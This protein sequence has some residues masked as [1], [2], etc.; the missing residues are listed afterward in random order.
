[1]TKLRLPLL[2]FPFLRPRPPAR[3][4]PPMARKTKTGTALDRQRSWPGGH[5]RP[6]SIKR[7]HITG[8]AESG[9]AFNRAEVMGYRSFRDMRQLARGTIN[10]FP[11]GVAPGV[12]RG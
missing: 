2:L 5:W 3:F 7:S 11:G 1:M 12:G 8:P 4:G 9:L 6:A 10:S